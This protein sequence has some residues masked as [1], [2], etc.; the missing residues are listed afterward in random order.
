MVRF[1]SRYIVFQ[2]FQENQ[3]ISGLFNTNTTFQRS[4]FPI[5]LT[6]ELTTLT[7]HALLNLIK[8]HVYFNFGDWG[9]G[10]I[11]ASLNIKYYSPATHTGIIRV[12]RQHYRL[13]WA[14]LTFIKTIQ[15]QPVLIRVLRI[16]GTIKKAEMFLIQRNKDLL[17]KEKLGKN[18]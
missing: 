17:I 3:L 9:Q 18:I 16:N 1:K 6:D 10:L 11:A 4:S 12:S 15:D 2:I 5:K 14:V 7:S 8:E 13:V